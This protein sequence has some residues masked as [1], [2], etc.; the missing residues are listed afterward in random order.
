MGDVCMVR[1]LRVRCAD[2]PDAQGMDI[3]VPRQPCKVPEF[4]S[5]HVQELLKPF[6]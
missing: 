3:V 5:G 2:V 4:F 1:D 6:C